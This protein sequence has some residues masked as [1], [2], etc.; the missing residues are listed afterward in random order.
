MGRSFADNERIVELKAGTVSLGLT[1]V[2]AVRHQRVVKS[3]L[4]SEF[5]SSARS[6]G[7]LGKTT[8]ALNR[9]RTQKGKDQRAVGHIISG[10]AAVQQGDA[11]RV[12]TIIGPILRRAL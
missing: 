4:G 1:P 11:M 6:N 10:H 8:V 2:T 3:P 7:C 12:I 9:S 5:K